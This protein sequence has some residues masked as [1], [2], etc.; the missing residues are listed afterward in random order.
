MDQFCPY[1]G[2]P[3][4]YPITVYSSEYQGE[5]PHGGIVE[6]EDEACTLCGGK[7]G[8]PISSPQPIDET[9]SIQECPF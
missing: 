1:C 2:E 4:G 8:S 3:G 7:P 6:W 5:S 9:E